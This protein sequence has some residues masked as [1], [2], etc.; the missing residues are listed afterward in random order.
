MTE[1]QM[2]VLIGTIYIAPHCEGRFSLIVGTTALI[3]AIFKGLG[4]V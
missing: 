3:V 2:L 1:T 4:W